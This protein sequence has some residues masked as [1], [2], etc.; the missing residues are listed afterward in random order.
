MLWEE[1][2]NFDDIKK[3]PY[4]IKNI[5]WDFDPTKLL[6]PMIK[7]EGDRIICQKPPKGYIFYIETSGGKP[8]LF[9]MMQKSNCFGETIAK[10]EEIPADMLYEAVEE[11]K[12][13]IKFGICPINDKIKKW[14][15][16][17]LGVLD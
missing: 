3:E 4:Y 14:L 16:E 8:E 11:N 7:Q 13:K 2:L 9:L 15:K 10:I 6:E 12:E 17:Q 5:L 1:L